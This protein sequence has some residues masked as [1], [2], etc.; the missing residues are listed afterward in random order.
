MNKYFF[1][2]YNFVLHLIY[3]YTRTRMLHSNAYIILYI[4]SLKLSAKKIYNRTYYYIKSYLCP[5]IFIYYV[6]SPHVR[7]SKQT[8]P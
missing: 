3:F 4:L 7:K 6:Y 5:D 2:L 8:N 1:I